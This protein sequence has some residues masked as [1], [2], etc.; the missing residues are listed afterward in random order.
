MAARRPTAPDPSRPAPAGPSPADGSGTAPPGTAA[1]STKEK[2]GGP[3][4][5][6]LERLSKL[7]FT[8]AATGLG[9]LALGLVL[10]AVWQLAAVVVH[11]E[12]LL[13]QL[14]QSVGLVVIAV[15]VFE[16]AK[17]LIEEEVLHERELRSVLE[18][19]RSLTK[20]FTTIIIAVS[21]EAIVLVFETRLEE[22]AALIY[23]TLL[24]AVAVFALIG[25]GLF[26]MLSK[27]GGGNRIGPDRLVEPLPG[28]APARPADPR[29]APRFG[30]PGGA[31]DAAD[32]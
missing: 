19:R 31:D 20:F 21:L 26:Q 24:M 4:E 27:S 17:F 28:Q 30:R 7:F 16:V 23:P 10:T 22:N 29:P 18:A 5:A 14:L 15:A 9:L 8:A 1:A 12:P 11:G 6:A 25:L 13:H 3:L 2:V 32:G